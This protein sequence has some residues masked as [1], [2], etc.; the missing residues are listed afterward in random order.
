MVHDAPADHHADPGGADKVFRGVRTPGPPRV[1]DGFARLLERDA[2][3]FEQISDQ[4]WFWMLIITGG[5]NES[6]SV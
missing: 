6:K 4:K 3:F 5:D 1:P 2:E